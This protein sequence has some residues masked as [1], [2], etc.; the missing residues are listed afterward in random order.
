[1]FGAQS[2]TSAS[3]LQIKQV[4]VHSIL[5]TNPTRGIPRNKFQKQNKSLNCQFLHVILYSTVNLCVDL[6]VGHCTGQQTFSLKGQIGN[7][8]DFASHTDFVTTINS[9]IS[10]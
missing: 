2:T 6:N 5:Y 9:A 1:M 3:S 4:Y 8:L 7:I 10:V